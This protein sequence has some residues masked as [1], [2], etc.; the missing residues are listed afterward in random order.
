MLQFVKII[1]D[2]YFFIAIN[3]W[4]FIEYIDNNGA[5]S[6]TLFSRSQDGTSGIIKVWQASTTVL[7]QPHKTHIILTMGLQCFLKKHQRNYFQSR[8]YVNGIFEL[9]LLVYSGHSLPY[10]SNNQKQFHANS[11]MVI[12]IL[13]NLA[14]Q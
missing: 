12:S 9:C 13:L 2:D 1:S 10:S 4:H 8:V 6:Q 11:F 5:S 7:H 3:G 14:S